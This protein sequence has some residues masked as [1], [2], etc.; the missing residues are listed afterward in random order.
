MTHKP[1]VTWLFE[2]YPLTSLGRKMGRK[3]GGRKRGRRKRGQPELRDFWAQPPLKTVP[4]DPRVWQRTYPELALSLAGRVP[5][6]ARIAA[7]SR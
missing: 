5:N 6:T 7:T 1:V 2:Y 4:T 3:R